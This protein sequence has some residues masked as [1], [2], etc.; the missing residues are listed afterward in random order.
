MPVLQQ[1]VTK[2]VRASGGFTVD[3]GDRI[4]CAPMGGPPRS[5]LHN[6]R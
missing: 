5:N 6:F 1:A 3:A 2:I 4:R